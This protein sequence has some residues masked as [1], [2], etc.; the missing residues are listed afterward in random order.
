MRLT[1]EKDA[2]T[3]AGFQK[4]GLSLSLDIPGSGTF[5]ASYETLM[6]QMCGSRRDRN[7]LSPVKTL[8]AGGSAGIC[9]WIV[10]IGP[11]V[12]KSRI[13]TGI[14]VQINIICL[15]SAIVL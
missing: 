14:D 3:N 10:S 1:L 8:L 2:E 13:Q 11:D 7:E 5:L 9:N 6:R 4:T 15:I 12:L